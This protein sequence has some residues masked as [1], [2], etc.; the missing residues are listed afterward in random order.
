MLSLAALDPLA[1]SFESHT[2]LSRGYAIL[3]DT[4]ENSI[5][6]Q[7]IENILRE[8]VAVTIMWSEFHS[9]TITSLSWMISAVKWY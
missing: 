7:V 1:S 2:L 9:L 6:M 8:F 3:E 4:K 5:S